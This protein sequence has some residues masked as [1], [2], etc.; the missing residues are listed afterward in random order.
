MLGLLGNGNFS[1]KTATWVAHGFDL[2]H[3]PM[4]EYNWIWSL[5]IM[6]KLKIFLW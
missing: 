4:W 1:T 6:P 2:V 5:D 3:K